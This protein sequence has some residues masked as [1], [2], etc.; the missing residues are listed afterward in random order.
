MSYSLP[1]AAAAATAKDGYHRDNFRGESSDDESYYSYPNSQK[2]QIS[3][4]Q[5]GYSPKD[6]YPQPYSS[7]QPQLP[8]Q[9]LAPKTE[10]LPQSSQAW[11]QSKQLK[12]LDGSHQSSSQSQQQQQLPQNPPKSNNHLPSSQTWEQSRQQEPLYGVVSQGYSTKDNHDHQSHR[13]FN[14]P[15]PSQQQQ[16]QQLPPVRAPLPQDPPKS[17]QTWDQSWQQEPSN[18][19]VSQGYSTKDNRDHQS[20]RSFN[21]PQPPSQREQQR[22]LP[23]VRAPFPQNPPKSSQASDRYWQQEPSALVPSQGYS[24]KGNHDLISPRSFTHPQPSSPQV[25]VIQNPQSQ[26]RQPPNEVP[27]ETHPSKYHPQTQSNQPQKQQPAPMEFS[28]KDQHPPKNNNQLSQ[29][30]QH[31][32]SAQPPPKHTVIEPSFPNENQSVLDVHG[33]A[34]G[35]R[36]MPQRP[37]VDL[38]KPRSNQPVV[39]YTSGPT[40]NPP[41]PRN[42]QPVVAYPDLGSLPPET[43]ITIKIPP[44]EQPKDVPQSNPLPVTEHSKKSKKGRCKCSIL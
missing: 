13:S 21:H 18:G 30:H 16:Q 8:V 38:A 6:D 7:K 23:P 43:V 24:T 29:Q 2:Q 15:Q 36:A 3:Q 1:G 39:A 27:W 35:N 14:H 25:P 17:S 31:Q 34:Q 19:V 11:D 33:T 22:Q 4:P 44:K 37:T 42:D 28:P 20:H 12:A 26:P 5:Q 40:Y 41:G 9:V 32:P 10:Y